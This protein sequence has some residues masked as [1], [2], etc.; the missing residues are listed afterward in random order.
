M[1]H[2]LPVEEEH[3]AFEGSRGADMVKEL[4][5]IIRHKFNKSLIL[6]LLILYDQLKL[7]NWFGLTITVFHI[8]P[9]DGHVESKGTLSDGIIIIIFLVFGAESMYLIRGRNDKMVMGGLL[10][11]NEQVLFISSDNVVRSI[12]IHVILVRFFVLNVIREVLGFVFVVEAI[13]VLLKD[14][15]N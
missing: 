12:L 2:C 7:R 5:I 1:L 13:H 9:L 8:F 14:F 10:P 4:L 15:I 11:V 6:R 3:E